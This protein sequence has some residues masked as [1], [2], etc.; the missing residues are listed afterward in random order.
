MVPSDKLPNVHLIEEIEKD[1]NEPWNYPLCTFENVTNNVQ[2]SM[3]QQG[4][5]PNLKKGSHILSFCGSFTL[6]FENVHDALSWKSERV[7]IRNMDTESTIKPDVTRPGGVWAHC[8]GLDVGPKW[9]KSY[10]LIDDF[11]RLRVFESDTAAQSKRPTRWLRS[12]IWRSHSAAW[13]K[14]SVQNSGC[15]SR[16]NSSTVRPC[17]ST[18]VKYLRLCRAFLS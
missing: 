4:Q 10:L 6:R 17:C 11:G 16:C 14:V 15:Q 7:S 9:T 1:P 2:C 8:Q 18:H 3:C 13:L 12:S 5:R